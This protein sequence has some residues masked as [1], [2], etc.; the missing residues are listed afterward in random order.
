MNLHQSGAYSHYKSFIFKW[1][2]TP[3]CWF[4]LKRNCG[5]QSPDRRCNQPR[6]THLGNIH[7]EKLTKEMLCC[8]FGLREEKK[9]KVDNPFENLQSNTNKYQLYS[10]MYGSEA[11]DGHGNTIFLDNEMIKNYEDIITSGIESD[12][13][14]KNY[15]KWHFRSFE[16]YSFKKNHWIAIGSLIISVFAII[17]SICNLL[18]LFWMG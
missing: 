6:I 16:E 4:P 15:I 10:E 11:I 14:L 9:D 8:C 18:L 1:F 17:I 3:E 13:A 2:P 7:Q 5:F 12:I